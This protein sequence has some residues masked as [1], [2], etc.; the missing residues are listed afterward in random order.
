MLALPLSQTSAQSQKQ[1]VH[2]TP[3][4]SIGEMRREEQN[5]VERWLFRKRRAKY[6]G[7]FVK[8]VRRKQKLNSPPRKSRWEK[9]RRVPW[10]GWHREQN[11]NKGGGWAGPRS[12]SPET[13]KTQEQNGKKSHFLFGGILSFQKFTF[14]SS[15]PFPV[16]GNSEDSPLVKT[17][18][19]VPTVYQ[20]QVFI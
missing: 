18:F 10:L 11:R 17:Q 3:E 16:C 8:E 20:S 19:Y 9:G 13:C 15:T 7:L 5:Q 2:S 12:T 14:L 6:K 1:M 4:M